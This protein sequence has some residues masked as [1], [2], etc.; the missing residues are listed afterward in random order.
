MEDLS[1]NVWQTII[2]TLITEGEPAVKTGTHFFF[3]QKYPLLKGTNATHWPPKPKESCLLPHFRR[4]ELKCVR[5]KTWI[6]IPNV[7]F[8]SKLNLQEKLIMTTTNA[9]REESDLWSL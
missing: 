3:V 6:I 4:Q 7:F 5:N 2:S 1:T 8:L 9:Q